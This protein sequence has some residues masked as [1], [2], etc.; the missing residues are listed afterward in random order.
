[1]NLQTR[2]RCVPFGRPLRIELQPGSSPGVGEQQAQPRQISSPPLTMRA[3]LS[4]ESFR[5]GFP[6]ALLRAL[7]GLV[8]MLVIPVHDAS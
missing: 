1:M 2:G 6:L 5:F 8:A 4:S 3:E 7:T